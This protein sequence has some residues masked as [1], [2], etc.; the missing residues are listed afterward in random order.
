MAFSAESCP[1]TGKQFLPLKRSCLDVNLIIAETRSV[2]PQT[3]VYDTEPSY[4]ELN[5]H[6]KVDDYEYVIF[7]NFIRDE[8]F[9]F[10]RGGTHDEGLPETG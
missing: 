4:E 7:C 10:W 8:M 6:V 5:L 9:W 1:D 3:A 2:S